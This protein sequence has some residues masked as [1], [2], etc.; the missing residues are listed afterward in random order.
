MRICIF[1]SPLFEIIVVRC[2]TLNVVLI[3]Q[4]QPDKVWESISEN[5]KSFGE[6]VQTGAKDLAQTIQKGSSDLFKSKPAE[7]KN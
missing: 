3:F 7:E 1:A 2:C 6:K 5:L 4:L